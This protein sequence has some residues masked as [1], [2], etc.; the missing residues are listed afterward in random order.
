LTINIEINV[1]SSDEATTAIFV[2]KLKRVITLLP[3]YKFKVQ[4]PET[5]TVFYN[6]IQGEFLPVDMLPPRPARPHRS[7]RRNSA[8]PYA[9]Y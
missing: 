1:T 6:Q 5:L 3:E 2:N 9:R 7:D 8:L 4:N